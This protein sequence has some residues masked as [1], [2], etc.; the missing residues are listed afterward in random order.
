MHKTGECGGGTWLLGPG[1]SKDKGAAP[2]THVPRAQ[3]GREATAPT[4]S[5]KGRVWKESKA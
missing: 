2:G 1:W 4:P 3:K 5:E